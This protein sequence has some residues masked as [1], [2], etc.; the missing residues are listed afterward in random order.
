MF[1]FGAG[2]TRL[3]INGLSKNGSARL[4]TTL[5][6]INITSKAKENRRSSSLIVSNS[7]NSS[8]ELEQLHLMMD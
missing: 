1:V 6:K 7:A 3:T 2:S 5:R 8:S 4:I